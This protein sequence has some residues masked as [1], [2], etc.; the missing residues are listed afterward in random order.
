[1]RY[2]YTPYYLL[3]EGSLKAL[4]RLYQGSIKVLSRLYQGSIK[5]QR[6]AMPHALSALVP[7]R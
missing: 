5:G 4:S 7:H 1:M 6:Y 3:S 2:T